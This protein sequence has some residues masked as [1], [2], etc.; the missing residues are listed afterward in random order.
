MLGKFLAEITSVQTLLLKFCI[1]NS[2]SGLLLFL[3]TWDFPSDP[4]VKI[5]HYQCRGHGFD[6]WLGN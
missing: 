3:K 1:L 5:L 2:D 4:F 6:P